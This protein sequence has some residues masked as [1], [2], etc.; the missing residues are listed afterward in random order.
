MGLLSVNLGILNLL[1]VPVLDGGHLVFLTIEAIRRKPLS[2]QV[3]EVSQ[4]V[5]IALLA[6]LMLFVFYNDIFRIVQR[7]TGS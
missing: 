2:E 5:G 4:K 3:M 1:P 7:W 6:T